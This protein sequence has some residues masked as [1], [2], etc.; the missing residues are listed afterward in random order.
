M[1]P[2]IAITKCCTMGD[3]KQQKY[4]AYSSGD[5]KSQIKIHK[6][7][8]PSEVWRE[9]LPCLF[10]AS[11]GLLTIFGALRRYITSIIAFIVTVCSS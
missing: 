4:I 7:H 8:I 10:L 2:R 6:G 9:I 5:Q 1:F 3:L 11:G